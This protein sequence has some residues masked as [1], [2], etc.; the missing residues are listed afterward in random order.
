MLVLEVLRAKF[1]DSLLL[2]FGTKAK[3]LLAVIDGGPPGVWADALQPVPWKIKRF[4][5]NSFDDL[6]DN[7]DVTVGASASAMSTASLGGLLQPE[8]SLILASVSEGRDL[9]NLLD[10][11][12]LAGNPPFKGLVRA[13]Q[14]PIPL[15][16]L[17][18]TVV[19]PGEKNL[20]AL[21][22]D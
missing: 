5:H 22:K 20:L 2:H 1:G 17:K 11:L 19:A 15:N 18:L 9:R 7:D 4:W 13:G 6:L 10:A 14:A 21:Q 12:K 8:G 16:N 3:P